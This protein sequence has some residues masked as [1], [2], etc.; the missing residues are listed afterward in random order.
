LVHQYK[1]LLL[2][3]IS[4][5][6]THFYIYNKSIRRGSDR[7]FVNAII[8]LLLN[9]EPTGNTG[10]TKRKNIYIIRHYKY[11]RLI[12]VSISIAR[13]VIEKTLLLN[14]CFWTYFSNCKIF[15]L[16][17]NGNSIS[18]TTVLFLFEICFQYFSKQ[19]LVR[20]NNFCNK[21]S[22]VLCTDLDEIYIYVILRTKYEYEVN[23]F[24]K[25][26]E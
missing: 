24:V 19:Y 14:S 22:W 16:V 23:D 3:C 26:F 10:R 9:D 1:K 8:L 20:G 25:C 21:P 17:W 12:R 15:Y 13:D 7:T 6:E 11:D 18:Y 2:K 5:K 4:R